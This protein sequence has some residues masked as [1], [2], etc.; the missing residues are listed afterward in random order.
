MGERMN[1]KA[2]PRTSA[3][4][5]SASSKAL[6]RRAAKSTFSEPG[7]AYEREA[8]RAADA[9]V[10]AAS[11]SRQ[12]AFSLGAIPIV[13][14]EEKPPGQ[15]T[16]E[17]KYK[18]A[19]K[20][21]G[22]AFLQ[23]GPGKEIK[24]KA[25][26]LGDT[27]IAT[28]P[29]K[30][31]TGA[32]IAGAVTALAA[33]HRELPI[34]IPEIS[35]DR[36]KPGLKMKITYEGPVDKPTRVMA[37]FS[38]KLGGDGA[39]DKKPATT[40]REKFRAQTAKMAAEQAKFREGLKTPDEKAADKRMMDAYLKS[41][42]LD[43]TQLTPR[44]SPLSFGAAGQQFGIKPS[45]ADQSAV[46]TGPYAPPDFKLTGETDQQPAQDEAKKKEEGAMQRKPT[47]HEGTV[48]AAPP[49]VSD[50]VR[51]SGQPLDAGTRA[52]ME[53]RF[54][55]DFS[56]VRI[57]T[58]AQA[59][60]SAQAVNALAYTAGE[61][62]IFAGGQYSPHSVEGQR[63]IAHELA[64]V[65]QQSGGAGESAIGSAPPQVMRKKTAEKDADTP[66]PDPLQVALNGDDDAVRA[67]TKH[68]RWKE[69]KLTAE[70]AAQLVI[71]LLDGATLNPDEQ[72]GLAILDKQK[73]AKL[74]DDSLLALDK[75]GRFPQLLDDYHGAEYK[76]LLKLLRANIENKAVK[77]AFLDAFIDMWS[78]FVWYHEEEAI[79]VLLERTPK[80]DQA[81][82]LTEKDRTQEL[83]DTIGNESLS[84][85]F[86]IIVV[87]VNKQQ[88]GQL[89]S[90]LIG[91]QLSALFRVKGAASV[92]KGQRTQAEVDALL[93]RAARDLA[94]E[95]ADYRKR[96]DA[97]VK[98]PKS[99]SDDIKKIN[100]EFEKRLKDLI[101]QKKAEFDM[102]LEYNI[103]FNRLLGKAFGRAW[104]PKELQEFSKEILSKIPY[105][106]LRANPD[107]AAIARAEAD[108]DRPGL[109]G[110]ADAGE[111]RIK[112]FGDLT[113]DNTAHEVGHFVQYDDNDLYEA[114]QK[115]SEWRQLTVADMVIEIPDQKDRD[116]L[117]KSL[118]ADY[119]T[120]QTD[121][122]FQGSAYEH[123]GYMY[124][125]ARGEGAG[126]YHRFKKG[127]C[128]V[129][130][131]AGTKPSDDFAES[132]GYYIGSPQVLQDKCPD[133]YEFMH[134]RVFVEYRLKKQKARM[135]KQFDDDVSQ[136]LAVFNLGGLA[137]VTKIKDQYVTALRTELE[138]KLDEQQAAKIA[139]AEKTKGN[140][141]VP[142]PM[143]AQ[144]EKL[145]QPYLSKL[146]AFLAVA[147]PV[148]SRADKF[149][150]T[151]FGESITLLNILQ[152]AY[153]AITSH[154]E[155][156]FQ[157]ELMALLDPPAQRA[158]KGE[159]VAVTA[160]PEL[161][162]LAAA[163]DQALAVIQP[164]LPL[165]RNSM[166]LQTRF[167]SLEAELL[168]KVPAGDK[169]ESLRLYMVNQRD[170]VLN[171]QIE[172]WQKDVLARIRNGTPYDPAQVNDPAE[173]WKRFEKD[174]RALARK[175]ARVRRRAA[176]DAEPTG[177]AEA[178]QRG[179]RSSAQPLDKDTR[180]F[181]QERFGADF[182][183]VRVHTGAQ[184]AQS[185]KA[186]N[187]KAF[188]AGNDVVF[189]E[190]QYAPDTPEG[191]QLLAHELTHVV[192][193]EGATPTAGG[194][195]GKG[196]AKQ[197]R[198]P[199]SFE[200]VDLPQTDAATT[201]SD[202]AAAAIAPLAAASDASP[203]G[204]EPGAEAPSAE[205]PKGEG[206][207]TVAAAPMDRAAASPLVVPPS[208]PSEQEAE[209]I[210]RAVVSRDAMRWPAHAPAMQRLRNGRAQRKPDP[211]PKTQEKLPGKDVVFIMGVDK[212]PK[213]NPFY[214]E[215]AKYFKA[216]LPNATLVNDNKRRSLESVFDFLRDK[217][218]R[219]A[220][221]YLVSHANEDGT[222]S[223][224]LRNA[225]KNADP[226][227]QYGEL[228][229]ALNDEAWLFNLPKGIIDEETRIYIKGC[230]IGR[231][232]R[233]LDALDKAFGG[234]GK[235]IAPTHKQVFGTKSVGKGKD[236]KVENYEAL[237]VYF[238]EYKGNQNISPADQQAAFIEKYPELPAAQ[239]KKW[240]PVNKRG[241]GGATRQL[242][243]TTYTY[244][245]E[246]KQKTKETKR[247]AE[248][249]ALPKA[250]A[251][252]E[253]NIGRADMFEWRV[254]SS[255]KTGY[256]WFVTCVAEKTNY[257]VDKILVDEAGQ[258][259][260]PAETDAKYFGTSTFGDEAKTAAQG[261]AAGG[262]GDTAALIAELVAIDKALADLPEGKA[263]DE[264][265]ARKREIEATLKER[266]AFVDVNVIKTEDWL[267]ADEVYV[268]LSGA[269]EPFTSPVKKL[270]D[271]QSYTFGVPLTALM[272][273][274]KPVKLEIFDQ[275]LGWFFDRDDLIVKM[276]WPPP[277]AEQ[278]NTESLDE[279]DYRVRA[280]L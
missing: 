248:E 158:L 32:A 86:E 172:R 149:A 94:S 100:R 133:K 51:S 17:E 151:V 62:V 52:M 89:E 182:G 140:K 30:V 55:F 201:A 84:K 65:V 162:Q 216:N 204:D 53:S 272:P 75:K 200:Q 42:L 23:T 106:I 261:N 108:P 47:S 130:P 97:A 11:V 190:N 185:A 234:E 273:F 80:Q 37:T 166:G 119:A 77:A 31:I 258:R 109:G 38:F 274:D 262:E 254:A 71:H 124:R 187:A 103:E 137:I 260:N 78:W 85:R 224:K 159:A 50:A 7:D 27:F 92:K 96:L 5:A 127:A 244:K 67:L 107:L 276:D 132:F 174:A 242:I 64:H 1:A 198:P 122:N 164:Y 22:E 26:Q 25:E 209:R 110:Q 178:V 21:V 165:Y 24:E 245:Y 39:R 207:E 139:E 259:L 99:D 231:S 144:G 263:R 121:K 69:I 275:D 120:A 155:S 81:S 76:E 15:K 232:T 179:L 266:K 171:P 180:G 111:K 129:S 280:R 227:V 176:N 161:D 91:P 48:S 83:R 221:L 235:V 220:N 20:K 105:D 219:V 211:K 102:E 229:T 217:G 214:R 34:G 167:N 236:R 196:D 269:G 195:S 230:N 46:G 146:R 279:A 152:D 278:T 147:K 191:Q 70:Q 3:T 44:T 197:A 193:Q 215:A 114:F 93:L 60:H 68:S 58:D 264:K 252:G 33:T 237:K 271:G 249:E 173:M 226:H 16:D 143:D 29:G 131:Y 101:E 246:I 277:F 98:N 36:I 112:L 134:V 222:L 82:L 59:A 18:Q 88:G 199:L 238:I 160:W 168:S 123:K 40:E 205:P 169:R 240:V 12:P 28:L 241:Q 63:L 104:K 268:Q 253:A 138:Q 35:L 210:S 41:K 87:E 117:L 74:L 247:M 148:A 251:W 136:G 202:R 142:I 188:T 203:S 79:V 153:N 257:V 13:Q 163:Y 208:H 225:D 113:L 8:D 128:F 256:G 125:F 243:S 157:D 57:H 170:T 154:L 54:G 184:A 270:N 49:I 141:P 126:I 118:D 213:K 4:S 192:Q 175:A 72:A 2:K 14:R 212:N 267:G 233:M 177:D 250:I 189:G 115:I 194:K 183:D 186:L 255:T 228:N 56:R 156:R 181:M 66:E 9:V 10:G 150:A 61:D 45:P 19:A 239:W 116:Q 135:L 223:F 90:Q 206:G 6:Q 218:E 265:L 95:L 145:A 43:P 73:D